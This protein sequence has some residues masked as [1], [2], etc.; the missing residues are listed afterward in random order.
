MRNWQL[1]YTLF[2]MIWNNNE[3][4]HDAIC[5]HHGCTVPWSL[6][7]L[8]SSAFLSMYLT[9]SSYWETSSNSARCA[10]G[11]ILRQ[12]V[13]APYQS[14]SLSVLR[15]KQ[16][17]ILG[18]EWKPR[19]QLSSGGGGPSRFRR[20][21]RPPGSFLIGGRSGP[22]GGRDIRE[23]FFF[24]LCNLKH[25]KT[26]F[27]DVSMGENHTQNLNVL[28]CTMHTSSYLCHPICFHDLTMKM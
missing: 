5:K 17:L 4:F 9:T 27:K 12:V 7:C 19:G 16:P 13:C 21:S 8:E 11:C 15:W 25:I 2:R 1:N 3:L 23:T 10:L 20:E 26:Y 24:F 28:G 22:T 6:R 14:T 18:I